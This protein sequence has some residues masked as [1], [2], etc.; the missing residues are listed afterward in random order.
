MPKIGLLHILIGFIVIVFAAMT[1]PFLANM[2]T[3]AFVHNPGELSGWRMTLLQS[4]HGHLT[5]FGVIQVLL[6]LTS[7]YSQLSGRM[8]QLQLALFLG[9]PIAMGPMM[10]LRAAEMPSDVLDWGGMAIGALL[11]CS[12]LALGMHIYGLMLKLRT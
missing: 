9:G 2:I 5:L 12:L 3:S 10:Y 7:V 1:G 11:T 4:A 8:K 6:G